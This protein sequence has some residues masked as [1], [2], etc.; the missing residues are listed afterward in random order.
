MESVTGT[1]RIAIELSASSVDPDRNQPRP[2]TSGPYGNELRD[3]NDGPSRS[4][5]FELLGGVIAIALL[6]FPAQLYLLLLSRPPQYTLRC[7]NPDWLNI[8]FMFFFMACCWIT[9]T[10]FLGWS[11]FSL[12]M[13]RQWKWKILSSYVPWQH[14]GQLSG[15]HDPYPQMAPDAS[16]RWIWGGRR[17][18]AISIVRFYYYG[19]FILSLL[20]IIPHYFWLA[21]V[22]KGDDELCK[23]L[24]ENGT[25]T[26]I[27]PTRL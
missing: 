3:P 5:R 16:W 11:G 9:L 1:S 14:V 25:I 8:L 2:H 12:G 13:L 20:M 4:I 24:L 27:H 26:S 19:W 7:N 17:F 15:I 22:L 6:P 10:V 21:D 18:R 23:N